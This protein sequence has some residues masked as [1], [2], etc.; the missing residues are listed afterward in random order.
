MEVWR[1]NKSGTP[2]EIKSKAFQCINGTSIAEKKTVY[3][4]IDS[5]IQNSTKKS[6]TIRS[7]RNTR[8]HLR[9]FCEKKNIDLKW[10]SFDFDFYESFLDFLYKQGHVDNSVGKTIKILKTFISSAFEHDLHTNLNFKK[11]WF[12]VIHSEADEIYL[13][14]EELIEFL[15]AD[16]SKT[17]N[18]WMM[19]RVKKI[20]VFGCWVGLRFGDLSRLNPNH[21]TNALGGGKLIKITT[22]KT[23]EDVMI[24]LLPLA[25]K[26]WDS[27]K[28]FPPKLPINAH[29]NKYIKEIAELAKIN[30]PVQ[31]RT[32]VKGKV[33]I[34]W[35]PKFTMV[36]A[37]TMRRSF[38]TNC[39]L[40]GVEKRDIMAVTGH[41]SEKSFLKYIRVSKE[42]HASRMAA[43]FQPKEELKM[44]ANK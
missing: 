3:S 35:V 21:I 10:D 17:E 2:E 37:H 4:F 39:Y 1:D 13:S 23:G 19:E 33:S 36:K 44:V 24:P 7:Y 38:A 25:D 9:A 42:Q 26:I 32:T 18:P 11:K 14:E 27:W 22:E 16:V 31:K 40:M 41:R 29:F 5:F 20:F 12:K 28:G 34:E 8:D 30:K 43:A 6:S 15:N